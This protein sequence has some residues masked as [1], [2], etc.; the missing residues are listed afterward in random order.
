MKAIMRELANSFDAI[1]KSDMCYEEQLETL[2]QATR[3]KFSI[4]RREIAENKV[5]KN[6]MLTDKNHQPLVVGKIYSIPRAANKFELLKEFDAND[7]CFRC[8]SDN[9]L[10]LG[11]EFLGYDGE[12]FVD[13]FEAT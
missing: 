7:E 10:H 8:T 9:S 13:V 12:D 4:E 3:A 5:L 2:L 11:R 6:K 1:L